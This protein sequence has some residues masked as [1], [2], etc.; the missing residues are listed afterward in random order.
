MSRACLACVFCCG[1]R[2]AGRKL[3]KH[4]L[5]GVCKPKPTVQPGLTSPSSPYLLLHRR[6]AAIVRAFVRC[7]VQEPDGS[8]CTGQ[9]QRAMTS[10]AMVVVALT[11]ACLLVF[12]GCGSSLSAA[13]F[14]DLPPSAGWTGFSANV[15]GTD[16]FLSARVCTTFLARSSLLSGATGDRGPFAALCVTTSISR[17]DV[18]LTFRVAA[19]EDQVG[20]LAS[21]RTERVRS[22]RRRYRAERSVDVSRGADQER[23][24]PVFCYSLPEMGRRL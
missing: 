6:F 1:F 9:K 15:D 24:R 10:P 22:V 13:K 14:R 2:M 16:G 12:S 11:V 4:F 3:C 18:A 5:E 7:C 19:R 20:L 17:D 23:R 8:A 21:G